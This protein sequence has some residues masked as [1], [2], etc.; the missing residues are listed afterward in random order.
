[1]DRIEG[2]CKMTLYSIEQLDRINKRQSWALEMEE[3][4]PQPKGIHSQTIE[5]SLGQVHEIISTQ[6]IQ[7]SGRGG[8][9]L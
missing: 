5:R 6:V 9:G 4:L 7:R 8:R 2:S 1:M 3:T